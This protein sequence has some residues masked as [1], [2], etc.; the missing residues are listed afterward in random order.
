ME[1]FLKQLPPEIGKEIFS[2]LLPDTADLLFVVPHK[3]CY[4]DYCNHR[5]E[6]AF[7]NRQLCENHQ[8]HYLSR[9]P[10][11]NGKHRYYI[12]YEMEDV[13]ETEHNERIYN[14]Y[15]YEYRS[16]YVGKNLKSALLTLFYE[17]KN[18][19]DY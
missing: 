7:I 10:K 13:L 18:L 14:Q 3:R 8:G 17:H 4:H 5:Y 15:M 11:K 19:T 6:R 12:T 16:K 9:I 2:Y 1:N